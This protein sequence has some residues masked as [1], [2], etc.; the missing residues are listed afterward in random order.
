MKNALS[1]SIT[2]MKEL[3]DARDVQINVK[4]ASTKTDNLS[5]HSVKK[6]FISTALPDNA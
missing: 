3:K 5:A 6:D 4:C 2:L 1:T